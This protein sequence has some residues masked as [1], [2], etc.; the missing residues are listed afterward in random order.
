MA[1]FRKGDI[2]N[3]YDDSQ[4]L[5]RGI[6]IDVDHV[7]T[8]TLNGKKKRENCL[9]AV[10]NIK[11]KFVNTFTWE[12]LTLEKRNYK[13]DRYKKKEPKPFV[14]TTTL[15]ANPDYKITVVGQAEKFM[16]G[17]IT[18]KVGYSI[19]SPLDGFDTKTGVNHA[20]KNL[21]NLYK[22][23][24]D[25]FMFDIYNYSKNIVKPILYGVYNVINEKVRTN[26]P[27]FFCGKMQQLPKI[28]GEI[29]QDLCQ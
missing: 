19:C 4:V 26:K 13:E 2:V 28:N 16:K 7:N 9:Y 22:A 24:N 17:A 20:L 29:K 25:N 27:V 15:E 14:F 23:N 10:K 3:Y 18:L 21:N 5:Q 6:I 11:N 12:V 8:S 1:K